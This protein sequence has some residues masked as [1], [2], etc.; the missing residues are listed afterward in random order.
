[1]APDGTPRVC[2]NV[3]ISYLT[4]GRENGE[5][6][7]KLTSGYGSRRDPAQDGGKIGPEFTFGITMD[8]AIEEPILIIKTAWGGKS[9][10]RDF[11]PPSS[12][13]PSDE[14]LKQILKQTNERN[15]KRKKPEITLDDVKD[16]YGKYYRLMIDHVRMVLKDIKRVYPEYN[17]KQ[18]YEIAGFVWFQGFNDMVSRS[19]YPNRDQEG[20]TNSRHG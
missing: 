18:G 3:W 9:I 7:G 20:G 5:G 8:K 15:K 11:R 19:V 13:L 4:G 14:K 1:R 17:K 6:F 12:G 10:G 2:D 16:G